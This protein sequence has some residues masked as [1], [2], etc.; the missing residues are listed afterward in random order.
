MA[1]T[2]RSEYH[3]QRHRNVEIESI[4]VTYAN[5]EKHRDQY[6]ICTEW[7]P[8]FCSATFGSEYESFQCDE[9][10]LQECH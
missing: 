2:N 8:Y 7:D 9:Q 6:V 10:E 1:R 3:M 5:H 4:V